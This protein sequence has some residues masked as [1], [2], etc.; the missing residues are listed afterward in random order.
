MAVYKIKT[1]EELKEA[2]DNRKAVIIP[3]SRVWN[4]YKPASVLLHLPGAIILK[5]LTLGIYI[6]E[7]KKKGD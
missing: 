6:Y 4:K 3:K 2:A 7:P 5:L 1:I